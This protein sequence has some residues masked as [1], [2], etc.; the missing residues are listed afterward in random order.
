MHHILQIVSL[1]ELPRHD[2]PRHAEHACYIPSPRSRGDKV[3]GGHRPV[4]W[5]RVPSAGDTRGASPA[6]NPGAPGLA[7]L[8]SELHD[9]S[10]SGVTRTPDPPHPAPSISFTSFIFFKNVHLFQR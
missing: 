6:A 10:A 7:L 5:S 1:A 9:A 8:H 2:G 3:A 4:G